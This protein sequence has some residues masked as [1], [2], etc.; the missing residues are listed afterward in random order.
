MNSLKLFGVPVQP[1]APWGVTVTPYC[2]S[3]MVEL[4]GGAPESCSANSETVV[5]AWCR[6]K[7]SHWAPGATTGGVARISAA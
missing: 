4:G 3:S 6:A 1:A 2:K 5:T 7:R